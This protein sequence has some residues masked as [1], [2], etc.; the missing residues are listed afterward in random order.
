M[1]FSPPAKPGDNVARV[2]DAPRRAPRRHR[3]DVDASAVPRG[4]ARR[5]ERR[6]FAFFNRDDETRRD[7]SV[8]D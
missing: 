6:F 3:H 8:D 4:I 5:E 1:R 7:A 2:S